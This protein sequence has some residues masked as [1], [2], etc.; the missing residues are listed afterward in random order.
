MLSSDID[1]LQSTCYVDALG[2]ISAAQVLAPAMRQ[3]GAG[4]FLATGG[5]A[6]VRSQP[7]YATISLGRS[8]LRAAATPRHEELKAGAVHATSVAIA[9]A[10]APGTPFGPD[11]I[12]DTHWDLHARPVGEWTAETVLDGDQGTRHQHHR[13]P[14]SSEKNRRRYRTPLGK[15]AVPSSGLALGCAV[16]EAGGPVALLCRDQA[17]LDGS[18]T[19]F[20][21]FGPEIRGYA[22]DVTD[23]VDLPAAISTAIDEVGSPEV[24]VC[25][26]GAVRMD[27]PTEGDAADLAYA[28]AVNVNGAKATRRR[29]AGEDHAGKDHREGVRLWPPSRSATL[30]G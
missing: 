17:T 11:R 19:E 20:A 14:H 15:P 21:A 13:D 5:Y 30:C 26:A 27:K 6:G 23:E 8:G 7:A 2:A 1:Y 3:A 29:V 12:A 10:I 4:T 28:S 25:N 24:L 16:A 9:G 22:A 18:A